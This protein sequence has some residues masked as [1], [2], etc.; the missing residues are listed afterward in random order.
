MLVSSL[1]EFSCKYWN[2]PLLT[3]NKNRFHFVDYLLPLPEFCGNCPTKKV[4]M[5][6]IDSSPGLDRSVTRHCHSNTSQSELLHWSVKIRTEHRTHRSNLSN[7]VSHGINSANVTVNHAW[8]QIET[9]SVYYHGT[10]STDMSVAMSGNK[11]W[12]YYLTLHHVDSPYLCCVY[13]TCLIC[14]SVCLFT[15]CWYHFSKTPFWQLTSYFL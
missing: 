14:L 5:S 2:I 12:Y 7:K 6:I 1:C 10:E 11:N 15:S 8:M 4:W 13:F 9:Q 3:N